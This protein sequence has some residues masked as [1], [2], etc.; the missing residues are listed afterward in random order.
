[1]SGALAAR[2]TDKL[3]HSSE[4]MGFF[5]GAVAALAIGIFVIGTGGAGLA[6]LVAAGGIAGAGI[7]EVIDSLS[8]DPGIT[9]GA[10]GPGSNNIL[11]NNLDAVAISDPSLCYFPVV[12]NHGPKMIVEGSKTVFY[13]CR[14][15]ARKGDS[16]ICDAKITTGSPNVLIGGERV[17]VKGTRGNWVD[18][19]LDYGSMYMTVL[20]AGTT[21]AG[22]AVTGAFMALSEAISYRMHRNNQDAF[23]AQ[24]GMNVAGSLASG[25]ADDVAEHRGLMRPE[26]LAARNYEATRRATSNA[27]YA[28]YVQGKIAKGLPYQPQAQW[29]R[30]NRVAW[31]LNRRVGPAPVPSGRKLSIKPGWGS[32]AAQLTVDIARNIREKQREDAVPQE[33]SCDDTSW[34]EPA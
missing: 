4:M 31:A 16:L 30:N 6:V 23:A 32:I 17:R 11:I 5:L 25:A 28:R 9:T 2:E 24:A 19:L 8:E 22:L 21:A 10:V 14:P 26:R 33:V 34:L 15:A 3:K 20:F 7:A 12:Y 13:G 1:M 27:M 18:T 29:A